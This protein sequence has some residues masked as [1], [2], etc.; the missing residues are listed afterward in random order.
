[1]YKKVLGRR[2]FTRSLQWEKVCLLSRTRPLV[3]FCP[4][5]PDESAMTSQLVISTLDVTPGVCVNSLLLHYILTSRSQKTRQPVKVKTIVAPLLCMSGPAP[6]APSTCP[7]IGQTAGMFA[8]Y[9]MLRLG[10]KADVHCALY[11]V[12]APASAFSGEVIILQ[13]LFGSLHRAF[14]FSYL[15]T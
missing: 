9:L 1:M 10:L 7:L 13:W 5:G 6:P 8:A 15:I 3:I 12:D 11:P 4:E 2:G 14:S